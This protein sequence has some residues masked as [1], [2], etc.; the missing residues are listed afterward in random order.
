MAYISTLMQWRSQRV[1]L[2]CPGLPLFSKN[3]YIMNGIVYNIPIIH[4][5]LS[6]FHSIKIF[7]G[8]PFIEYYRP[9]QKKFL[10]TPLL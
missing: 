9:T 2:I 8:N 4:G 7:I 5:I 3:K 1:G 6:I 10:A